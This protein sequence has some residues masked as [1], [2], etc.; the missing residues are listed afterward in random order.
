MSK[1]YINTNR[2]AIHEFSRVNFGDKRLNSR[3][4]KL[5]DSFANSPEKSINQ[6]CE[7]WSQT[8]AA[9]R[10]FQND[11]IS[12]SEILASHVAKT[13]ERSVALQRL[14]TYR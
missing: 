2:W 8:K 5:T 11:A 7:G 12:E 13:I 14:P 4:I 10:F 1:E 6:A 9:Y 3:L